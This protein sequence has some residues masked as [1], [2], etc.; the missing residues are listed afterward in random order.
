[1]DSSQNDMSSTLRQLL[2]EA[3]LDENTDEVSLGLAALVC[4]TLIYH[5]PAVY[6]ALCTS[7]YKVDS[8]EEPPS[9]TDGE[10]EEEE[11]GDNRYLALVATLQRSVKN[12]SVTI[13]A[14]VKSKLVEGLGTYYDDPACPRRYLAR[15]EGLIDAFNE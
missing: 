5:L 11:E 2:P 10:E 14:E 9:S 3:Y 7:G 12:K 1:M 8:E 4:A 15:V 13:S 6:R